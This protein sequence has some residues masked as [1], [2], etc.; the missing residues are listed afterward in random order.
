M[1]IDKQKIQKL[2]LQ[3]MR[4][5]MKK[6]SVSSCG[7]HDSVMMMDNDMDALMPMHTSH[8]TPMMGSNSM[9][10]QHHMK[11]VSR[12]DCCAAVMCLIECCSCPV[13]KSALMECCEDIMSG[14]YD[15]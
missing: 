9:H 6:D 1:S 11:S 13:T 8:S 3:E 7:D 10:S 5:M 12:E 14:A 15:H 2:I 4:S